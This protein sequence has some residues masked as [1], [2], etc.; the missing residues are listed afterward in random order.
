[1]NEQ[2]KKDIKSM[3]I[4]Y[5]ALILSVIF[6]IVV[7]VYLN[8]FQGGM[9]GEDDKSLTNILLIAGSLMGVSSISAGIYIFNKRTQNITDNDIGDKIMIYRS[10]MIVRAATIGGV[11]FF[12]TVI[13]LLTASILG[14]V[15]A[16]TGL[17]ILGFFFPSLD[18]LSKEMK[19]NFKDLKY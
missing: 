12:F 9:G 16:I 13:Y 14:L 2:I 4:I 3:Q 17:L 10:A 7:T 5:T 6:F 15:G 1:M 18:R 8:I 11:S 19:H